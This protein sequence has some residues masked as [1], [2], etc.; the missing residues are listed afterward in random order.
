MPSRPSTAIVVTSTITLE[1]YSYRDRLESLGS[2]SPRVILAH[3]PVIIGIPHG[4]TAGPHFRA[5]RNH[6]VEKGPQPRQS[7]RQPHVVAVSAM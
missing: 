2:R 4:K 5:H 1:R 3:N 7:E 6:V